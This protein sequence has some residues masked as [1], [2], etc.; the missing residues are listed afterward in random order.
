MI[1]RFEVGKTYVTQE[2]KEVTVLERVGDCIRCS[3]TSE[4]C[5]DGIHR[6]DR[7]PSDNERGLDL[8]RVTGTDHDF[9]DPRNL[10][11]IQIGFDRVVALQKFEEYLDEQYP[12]R[13]ARRAA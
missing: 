1:P 6:Y 2:G 10:D 9:S 8:G 4:N 5:P 3:D 7:Q 13:K 12:H 11:P